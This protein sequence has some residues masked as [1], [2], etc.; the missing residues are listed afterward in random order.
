MNKLVKDLHES[1]NTALN[2]TADILNVSD[3]DKCK[4]IYSLS[5]KIDQAFKI[6]DG[7]C[8]E[9]GK[10]LLNCS[11]E[12]KIPVELNILFYGKNGGKIYFPEDDK[13]PLI[14]NDMALVLRDIHDLDKSF[15]IEDYQQAAQLKRLISSKGTITL[16]NYLKK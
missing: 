16:S 14:V 1:F 8:T 6:L 2:K 5:D 7:I 15:Y 3:S 10:A 9:F 12:E 11:S 13:D 4:A